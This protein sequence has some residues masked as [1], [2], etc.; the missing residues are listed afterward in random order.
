MEAGGK[1]YEGTVTVVEDG[2]DGPVTLPMLV[3]TLLRN[4]ADDCPELHEA[5]RIKLTARICKPNRELS[6]PPSVDNTPPP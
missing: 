1:T 3:H 5:K 2:S 4:I 6:Q